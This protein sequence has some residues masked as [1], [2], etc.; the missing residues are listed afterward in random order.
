M[1]VE[2]GVVVMVEQVVEIAV[3][4]GQAIMGV[5]QGDFE[6]TLKGDQSPLTQGCLPLMAIKGR[7]RV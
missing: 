5:Y 3:E 1:F 7:Q 6:V 4:A 2:F